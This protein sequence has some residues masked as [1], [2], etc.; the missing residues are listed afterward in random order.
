MRLS[1]TAFYY[2]GKGELLGYDDW[3]RPLYGDPQQIPFQMEIEPYSSELAKTNYGITVEV[4]YRMFTNPDSNLKLGSEIKY[5]EEEFEIQK[6][7]DYDRHYE[8]LIKKVGGI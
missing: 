1:K 7:W 6:V 3:G 2:S 4:N 5:R 8:L